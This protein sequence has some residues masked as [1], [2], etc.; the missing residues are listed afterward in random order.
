[1]RP[2]GIAIDRYG[3][4]DVFNFRIIPIFQSIVRVMQFVTH[5]LSTSFK[6]HAAR[7]NKVAAAIAKT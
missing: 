4:G 3:K 7:T 6:P 2:K 5:P 1:M